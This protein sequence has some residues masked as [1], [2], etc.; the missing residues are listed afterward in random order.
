MSAIGIIAEYN[1]FHSGHAW[2]LAAARRSSGCQAVIVTM[3]G[4]F[5]QRG[6]AAIFDK[7]FRAELAVLGGADL[8]LE[9]PFAFACRSAETFARGSVR[10]LAACG[11]VSHLA[12]GAETADLSWLQQVAAQKELPATQERLRTA[13]RAGLPYAAALG[14]ALSSA[15]GAAPL[16]ALPNNILALEYLTALARYAPRI[17][18]L[19]LPR[20]GAAHHAPGLPASGFASATALRQ[21]LHQENAGTL[22]PFFPPQVFRRLT[23]SAPPAVSMAALESALLYRLRSSSASELA[24]LPDLEPGLEWRLL[25]CARTAQSWEELLGQLKTRRYS[26]TRLQRLLVHALLGFTAEAASSLAAAGPAYLR[27][28][29]FSDRGRQ[30][31]H[32]LKHT[33]SL[34]VVL[35]G[36]SLAPSRQL[37]QKTLAGTHPLSAWQWE[38]RATDLH[39]LASGQAGGLDFL[40]SPVYV[41]SQQPPPG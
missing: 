28:L 33:A 22:A 1:P 31:L 32:T 4:S 35:R 11:L 38:M 6:E 13:L 2:Q 9:L 30:L 16:L 34:P 10:L 3:S 20:Q 25:A 12:F 14:R 23:H 36:A 7:W 26:R 41:S 40:R 27:V 17:Q 19:A 37:Q 18:P 5:V 24:L 39:A 21:A 29:A 8:V 15:E